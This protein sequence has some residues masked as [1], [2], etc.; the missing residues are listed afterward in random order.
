V[1]TIPVF[2]EINYNS[3]TTRYDLVVFQPSVQPA[4]AVQFTG[5][6]QVA[7]VATTA[8]VVGMTQSGMMRYLT[9]SGKVKVQLSIKTDAASDYM[10]RLAAASGTL[11][12]TV[13]EGP[14]ITWRHHDHTDDWRK[15]GNM[16]GIPTNDGFVLT[17]NYDSIEPTKDTAGGVETFGFL[18]NFVSTSWVW[19]G[20]FPGEAEFF[21]LAMDHNYRLDLNLTL[22][23][24]WKGLAPPVGI[25]PISV[26][27][28][29]DVQYLEDRVAVMEAVLA[30]QIAA[31]EGRDQVAGWINI[32]SEIGSGIQSV[33]VILGMTGEFGAAII[34]VGAAV[35]GVA[36]IMDGINSD[37]GVELGMG[38]LTE[39]AAAG[40]TIHSTW[41]KIKKGRALKKNLERMG[42][43]QYKRVSE[44]A[45]KMAFTGVS[46]ESLAAVA[47]YRLDRPGPEESGLI[48]RATDALIVSAAEGIGLSEA[49]VFGTNKIPSHGSTV[50][51]VPNVE[52]LNN[53]VLGVE[54]DALG[55]YSDSVRVVT[56]YAGRPASE[57]VLTRRVYLATANGNTRDLGTRDIL[58]EFS[59]PGGRGNAR[60]TSAEQWFNNETKDWEWNL[61][62]SSIIA[63]EGLSQGFLDATASNRAAFLDAVFKPSDITVTVSKKTPVMGQVMIEAF[64]DR[65]AASLGAYDTLGQNCQTLAQDFYKAATAYEMPGHWS[66]SDENSFQLDY[67]QRENI[68]SPVLTPAEVSDILNE[69]KGDDV[70]RQYALPQD[71]IRVNLNRID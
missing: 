30:S 51:W 47:E 48:A 37:N 9:D 14:E 21:G 36:S 61:S 42:T 52:T 53:N 71:G 34:A 6:V 19:T 68:R 49:I 39:A 28:N 66:V 10:G 5:T 31:I 3:N 11:V 33:G 57:G 54:H 59:K 35:S 62:P 7:G 40:M 16:F 17:L 65:Y 26:A 64:L 25:D 50:I 27:N 18:V 44:F 38:I 60:F 1:F 22:N 23:V 4:A 15:F 2:A 12:L 45:K 63:G 56:E 32:V 13:S 29:H 24:S 70:G 58:I 69:M 55:R 67:L 43:N 41:A 46:A 8:R 20:T